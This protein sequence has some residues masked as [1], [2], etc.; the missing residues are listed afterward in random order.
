[1]E[2]QFPAPH[3]MQMHLPAPQRRPAPFDLAAAQQHQQFH[4]QQQQ[5]AAAAAAQNY[6]FARRPSL[7]ASSEMFDPATGAPFQQ[8]PQFDA[9]PQQ[10]QP[11]GS[12]SLS[13]RS[14]GSSPY[15]SASPMPTTP[16]GMEQPMVNP[17]LL[18][19]ALN[20][21][22]AMPLPN[23]QFW[24][25]KAP[26]GR[27]RTNQACEK[28]RDRKTKCTGERPSCNRCSQRGYICEYASEHRVRGPAKNRRR[29]AASIDLTASTPISPTFSPSDK[30]GDADGDA[31]MSPVP[32]SGVSGQ[33]DQWNQLGG[34]AED[35]PPVNLFQDWLQ[36]NNSTLGLT[37][38]SS[39]AAKPDE[40]PGSMHGGPF[41]DMP[42]N[43]R[44]LGHPHAPP[45]GP[46]VR[47]S[48]SMPQL[49]LPYDGFAQP[50]PLAPTVPIPSGMRHVSVPAEAH[51]D[52]SDDV[53][54]PS[55]PFDQAQIMQNRQ[56]ELNGHPHDPGFAADGQQLPYA[57]PPPLTHPHF[58]NPDTAAAPHEQ[59]PRDFTQPSPVPSSNGYWI[60]LSRKPAPD[61]HLPAARHVDAPEVF[62]TTSSPE[63]MLA[64]HLVTC[65]PSVDDGSSK[66]DSDSV[67]T[68]DSVHTRSGTVDSREDIE[69]GVVAEMSKDSLFDDT[70]DQ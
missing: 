69:V 30:K 63:S 45:P 15:N 64:E 46:F 29:T 40:G 38:A 3:A 1:M 12:I 17:W 62:C 36:Q 19:F 43:G 20:A 44:P 39:D 8:H 53:V 6:P 65:S 16:T 10:F 54:W 31:D 37:I 66:S 48:L 57:F 5:A 42:A 55:Q 27:Q 13:A 56:D 60:A 25:G 23:P 50:V 2:S 21:M 9:Y 49:H 14:S 51:A 41:P 67:P 59:A 26:P 11:R 58:G 52:G 68:L 22:G 34:I 32:S 61:L 33:E 35:A 47:Y 24:F 7:P 4:L 70:A 28:C 18:P